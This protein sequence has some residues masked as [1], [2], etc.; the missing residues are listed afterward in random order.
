MA[1]T[2]ASKGHHAI[3]SEEKINFHSA[4]YNGLSFVQQATSRLI[5]FWVSYRDMR[6]LYA[7]YCTPA[8]VCILPSTAAP[9]CF[10]EVL[11]CQSKKTPLFKTTLG[12]FEWCDKTTV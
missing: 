6:S 3:K 11:F 12:D 2:W 8:W 4:Q 10:S 5:D 1:D 7:R 9:A